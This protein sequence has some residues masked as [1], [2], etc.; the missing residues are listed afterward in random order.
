MQSVR[1]ELVALPWVP[2]PGC[3]FSL[4]FLGS[5]M[6]PNLLLTQSEVIT[7][8]FLGISGYFDTSRRHLFS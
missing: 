8:V 3:L 2:L 7:M 1:Q 4:L 5:Q 6:L